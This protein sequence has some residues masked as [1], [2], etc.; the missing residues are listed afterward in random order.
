MNT[1]RS[2]SVLIYTTSY[3]ELTLCNRAW[4]AKE[5]KGC[6]NNSC[7]RK[8]PP[9]CH[10]PMHPIPLPRCHLGLSLTGTWHSHR[11]EHRHLCS[12]RG[13]V[14]QLWELILPKTAWERVGRRVEDNEPGKGALKPPK[15]SHLY[16]NSC[17]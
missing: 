11:S 9:G 17:Y 10:R 16:F 5:G 6:Q 7:S 3:L 15:G 4:A 1:I 14:H 8:A 12:Q 13:K 2:P